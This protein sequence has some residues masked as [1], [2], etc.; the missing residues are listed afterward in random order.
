MS[1]ILPENRDKWGKIILK[2]TRLVEKY[3]VFDYEN[4][5]NFL[6]F[7]KRLSDKLTSMY[8]LSVNINNNNI[9]NLKY[10]ENIDSK[11]LHLIILKMEDDYYYVTISYI[12]NKGEDDLD[13]DYILDQ[14]REL[15]K[16]LKI[17]FS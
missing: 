4:D 2:N 5:D 12:S 1:K 13:F 9:N 16:F 14:E 10:V 7:D 15:L 11:V 3:R 8:P 17:L 6:N